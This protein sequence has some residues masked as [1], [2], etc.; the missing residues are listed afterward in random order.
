MP[1]FQNPIG[2]G[3]MNA[4]SYNSYHFLTFCHVF[5]LALRLSL[6]STWGILSRNTTSTT[7]EVLQPFGLRSVDPPF[8]EK[9]GPEVTACC[10]CERVYP[11]DNILVTS[12]IE[13][14]LRI[15]Y[16]TLKM[17]VNTIF[18]DNSMNWTIQDFLEV[19]NPCAKK[20]WDSKNGDTKKINISTRNI[21]NIISQ[22]LW[23][24]VWLFGFW[25]VVEVGKF[26]IPGISL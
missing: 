17:A 11:G 9:A 15:Q 19:T 3:R 8:A 6:V 24:V 1:F 21:K 18:L 26:T 20:K 7:I 23:L 4:N 14:C 10:G 2:R 22:W 13:N 16:L 12:L 25:L 5:A